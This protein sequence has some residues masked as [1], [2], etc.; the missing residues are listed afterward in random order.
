MRRCSVARDAQAALALARGIPGRRR[1]AY[2]AGDSSSAAPGA[3]VTPA[4]ATASPTSARRAPQ[5]SPPPSEPSTDSRSHAAPP[6]P[7]APHMRRCSSF[8][9]LQHARDRD[10]PTGPGAA[11][12]GDGGEAG[13]APRSGS[14]QGGEGEVPPPSSTHSQPHS[15]RRAAPRLSQSRPRPAL[16]LG[17]PIATVTPA[18][19]SGAGSGGGSG[20]QQA[21]AGAAKQPYFSTTMETLAEAFWCAYLSLELLTPGGV[22][23]VCACVMVAVV[24]D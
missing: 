17:A 21:P 11:A 5:P 23:D 22:P 12:G 1:R 3:N 4:V 9:T 8:G 15:A 14:A 19:G 16:R 18:V 13:G 7:L 2:S 6:T 10:T 20:A 24:C